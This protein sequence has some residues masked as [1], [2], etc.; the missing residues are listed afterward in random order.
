MPPRTTLKHT[1]LLAVVLVALAALPSTAVANEQ[2]PTPADLSDTSDALQT[3]ET[4]LVSLDPTSGTTDIDGDGLSGIAE[5]RLGTNPSESDTDGDG[6]SDGVERNRGTD[7]LSADSDGDGLGDAT[8][9]AGS[10]DPT[11]ADSDG[12]GLSDGEEN[13]QGT[14]PTLPDTDGDGLTDSAEVNRINSNPLVTDSDG[15]FLSDQSEL[16]LGGNPNDWLSPITVPG[17]LAG[18]LFGVVLSVSIS[19][20]RIGFVRIIDELVAVRSLLGGVWENRAN[21]SGPATEDVSEVADNNLSD[22][23]PETIYSDE[24]RVEQLLERNEGR[25][26]QSSIVSK[27]DWSKSK[28]SR[29]LSTMADNGSVIKITIGRENLIC[30]PGEEPSIV[31]TALNSGEHE[32]EP[33]PKHPPSEPTPFGSSTNTE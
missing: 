19:N 31:R 7:P 3:T 20:R 33:I 30:L 10:T 28:V 13:E 32:Q 9:L 6:V 11:A 17:T 1:L 24:A 25:M 8:E 18:F 12:D 16:N 4:S 5:V 23:K 26:N 29:L 14:V 2:I 27:T 22:P 21:R 15:D